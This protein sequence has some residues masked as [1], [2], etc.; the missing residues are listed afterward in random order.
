MIRKIILLSIILVIFVSNVSAGSISNGGFESVGTIHP[1]AEPAGQVS[2]CGG[3]P[4]TY[5]YE[6]VY[7]LKFQIGTTSPKTI[8]LN[9]STVGNVVASEYISFWA[10]RPLS[11]S[12]GIT[13]V[14]IYSGNTLL[15]TIPIAQ[16]TNWTNYKYDF[17]ENHNNIRIVIKGITT[18]HSGT[19]YVYQAFDS[20][21]CGSYP[22]PMVY[23]FKDQCG[24]MLENNLLDVNIN[25][26]VSGWVYGYNVNPLSFSNNYFNETD[27][28]LISSL[29]HYSG[30]SWDRY[31]SH[32]GSEDIEVSINWNLA[33]TVRN[34][35]NNAIIPNAKL[36]MLFGCRCAGA[37]TTEIKYTGSDGKA[38]FISLANQAIAYNLSAVG[39]T[40]SLGDISAEF[41][42]QIADYGVTLYLTPK[43]QDDPED[44]EDPEDPTPADPMSVYFSDTD[45]NIKTQ[46]NNDVIT[47]F[48]L[49]YRNTNVSGTLTF[50]YLN[51]TSY[52][53]LLSWDVIPNEYD[54]KIISVTKY[55]NNFFDLS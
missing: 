33:V 10:K 48:K 40:D 52:E 22:A 29:T 14:S 51:D 24:N 32:G 36:D 25:N 23:N 42:P 3:F 45:N 55:I 11:T 17:T 39:Y 47:N 54:Y 5:V 20:F 38:T 49:W 50:E 4:G 15:T 1:W 13:E 44:P 41:S 46:F 37:S 21:V 31:P 16:S 53:T 35:S 34:A 19:H 28:L 26:T 6:G 9:H 43:P 18:E 7:G 8:Y 2:G 30:M 12:Y 27:S